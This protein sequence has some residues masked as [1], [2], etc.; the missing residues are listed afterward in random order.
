[1][2]RNVPMHIVGAHYAENWVL[3]SPDK[4]MDDAIR[5]AKPDLRVEFLLCSLVKELREV[6]GKLD[7]LDPDIRQKYLERKRQVAKKKAV[8]AARHDELF[9]LARSRRSWF[10]PVAERLVARHAPPDIASQLQRKIRSSA[11]K[12]CRGYPYPDEFLN[13]VKALKG[14][15][16][17]WNLQAFH[18][19]GPAFVRTWKQSLANG[20]GTIA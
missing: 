18:G 16:A 19:I 9:Q 11:E 13:Y 15:P 5:E 2:G 4:T 10:L 8:M 14:P 1:M 6:N 12:S 3:G 20:S 17:Q 7:M